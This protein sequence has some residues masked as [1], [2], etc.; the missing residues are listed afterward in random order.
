MMGRYDTYRR[1]GRDEAYTMLLSKDTADENWLVVPKEQF[2]PLSPPLWAATGSDFDIPNDLIGIVAWSMDDHCME[3]DV[4]VVD[5]DVPV[6]ESNQTCTHEIVEL[7]VS[8]RQHATCGPDD[9]RRHRM[10]RQRNFRYTVVEVDAS[11]QKIVEGRIADPLRQLLEIYRCPYHHGGIHSNDHIVRVDGSCIDLEL[12]YSRWTDCGTQ[13]HIQP[14]APVGVM[15]HPAS[16]M[17]RVG[18]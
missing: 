15:L 14:Y 17:Y 18:L 7:V 9:T 1:S 3:M 13:L 8:Y 12:P 2:L 16:Q 11:I 4:R 5:A 10:D 6:G